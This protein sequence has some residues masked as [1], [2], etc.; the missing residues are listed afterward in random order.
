M[1]GVT[2]S[3]RLRTAL[4]KADGPFR[5]FLLFVMVGAAAA[6]VH[7][8]TLIALA[9]GMTVPPVAASAAGFLAGGVVSYVLNY[10][11]V[12]RSERS[13]APT[14]AKFVAVAAVGLT[15]NSAILWA[16]IHG[17]SLHYL[18]AQIIATGLVMVWSFAANRYWTFGAGPAAP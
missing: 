16:L 6:V 2:P 11:H 17:A 12:F 18:P 8:G 3:N 9:E 5:Q 14:A 7:Y 4:L 15:L 1:N 13:H 10:S